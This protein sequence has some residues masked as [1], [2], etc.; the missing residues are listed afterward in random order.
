[1]ALLARPI[2]REHETTLC[3]RICTTCSYSEDRERNEELSRPAQGSRT[4]RVTRPWRTWRSSWVSQGYPE[5]A[6]SV[7]RRKTSVTAREGS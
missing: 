7:G 6:G 4:G 2:D 1:M 5:L 3:I